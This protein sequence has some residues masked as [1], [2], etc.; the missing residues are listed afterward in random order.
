MWSRW[1]AR[2]R[3]VREARLLA[4]AGTRRRSAL[5]A[6]GLAGLGGLALLALLVYSAVELARFDRVETRRAALVYAAPQALAAGVQVNIA[7]LAGTLTRLSY[8][9]TQ[10]APDA[11]GQF[12]RDGS[13]WEIYLR[14]LPGLSR[15]QRVRVEVSDDR[16]LRVTRDGLDIGAAALEP[17]ILASAGDRPG[18][19]HRPVRLRDVPFSLLQAVLAAED[20]RFF[21]HPGVDLRGLVRA[22]WVNFRAGRV[23]QGGSTITQQ[24]VKNRLLDP[25]R[26]FMRKLD[27]AWLATLVEWRYSKERILEAYLNEVYLGQR[28]PMAIRGVSSAS[29]AYFGKEVHELTVAES[30]LLAGMIRAPNT[31]SPSTNPARARE[32]RDVVLGRMRELGRLSEADY[33]EARREPVRAQLVVAATQTAPYFADHVRQ[34]LEARLG[35]GALDAR[36]VRVFTSLDLTLQ[37]L[38]ESAVERGLA[39][40]E[41]KRPTL[42]GNDNAHR[43]QA[44]L[45]VLDPATGQIRALVGGRSYQASQFN[46]ATLAHRQPGSAFKPFVYAAALTAP[47]GGGRGFTAATFLDDSPLTLTVNGAPWSPRNYEDRYQGRVTVREALQQSLNAATVRLAQDVALPTIVHRGHRRLRARARRDRRRRGQDRDDQRRARRVVRRRRPGAAGRGVG[48]LRQ[49]RTARPQRG[50]GCPA[51]LGG[52]H[53]ARARERRQPRLHRAVGR[54]V[55]R[56]RSHQ[57]QAR[58]PLLPAHREGGLPQRH[59]ARGLPRARWP[60]RPRGGLVEPIPRLAAALTLVALAAAAC[61]PTRRQPPTAASAPTPTPPGARALPP[62]ARAVWTGT[63]SWYG[64]AHHRKKT[65]SGEPFDMHAL[66]AAH[67]TLPFGTRVLVTNL[68]NGRAVE[69]RINDRGPVVRDRIIDLSYGA[70]RALDAVGAGVFRVRIAV[71]E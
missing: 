23:A 43:L 18:E 40:L 29:R 31:Y 5:V 47:P 34:E 61:A 19:D 28:G 51:D 20:H 32:R 67:R 6:L 59:R 39:R 52:V 50:R 8:R 30:A 13:D 4:W 64:E 66:T 37:R 25:K 36:D 1:A 42:R 14:G 46:R 49:R 69:V 41:A 21:D 62:E 68:A 71:L 17:E 26:T 12:Q 65:A 63:A 15:V 3:D 56:D 9:E 44:A 33:Q 7:D 70:A 55:R 45:V 48:R 57:R 16:I 38:A 22:A 27:E 60:R 35:S 24:L 10:G 54:D 53:A 2:L 11:P 58:E